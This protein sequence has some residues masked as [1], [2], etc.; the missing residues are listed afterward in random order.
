[1]G[2]IEEAIEDIKATNIRNIAII[3]QTTFSMERFDRYVKCIK[4]NIPKD[5][6]LE[7]NK[8]ICDS[9]RMRQEE[10]KEI[11]KQVELMI[12][13]GGK[14]SANTNKLYEI[15]LDFC[16][17]A[18]KVETM[19][20]L[21]LN[22]VRRFQKVGVMAGASTPQEFIQEVVEAIQKEE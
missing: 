5:S 20:D 16:N 11:A 14:N 7:I 8:T 18:M 22:Y 10:T 19:E 4:R 9:T 12:I 13:I 21:Y 3:S 1:M 6:N 2:N 15:A 17:N